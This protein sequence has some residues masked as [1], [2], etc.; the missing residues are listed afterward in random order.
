MRKERLRDVRW[1]SEGHSDSE[2]QRQVSNT[3]P[4]DLK[5]PAPSASLHLLLAF[6]GM[7]SFCAVVTDLFPNQGTL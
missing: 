6:W 3:E 7:S 4:S 1:L 5:D 2:W